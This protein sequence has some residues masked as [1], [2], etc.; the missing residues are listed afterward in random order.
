VPFRIHRPL[1]TTAGVVDDV[2]ETVADHLVEL[3]RLLGKRVF[4]LR[5]PELIETERGPAVDD[6]VADAVRE[7]LTRPLTPKRTTKTRRWAEDSL[8]DVFNR[9]QEGDTERSLAE[10]IDLTPELSELKYELAESIDEDA[11]GLDF[12]AR[13]ILSPAYPALTDYLLAIAFHVMGLREVNGIRNFILKNRNGVRSLADYAAVSAA[14]SIIEREQLNV[15]GFN[16]DDGDIVA[17]IRRAKLTLSTATFEDD[18]RVVIDDQIFNRRELQLIEDAE[19]VI[20]DI[21]DALKP[22]LVK[23]IRSSPVAIEKSNVGFFLPLFISQ[24]TG[25]VDVGEQDDVALAQSDR[26][27]EVEFFTDDRSQIQVSRSAVKCAAQLY[28]TM[29]LGDELGVFDVVNFFT[30]KYLLREGFEIEDARLRNDLQQYVFSNKFTVVDPRTNLKQVVERTRPAERHMFYRQVFDTN[31]GEATEDLIVN[32]EFSRL[33]KVLILESAKYLQRAQSSPHPDAFVSPQPVMQAVEDLQYNLS[34]H[35]TG[36][37]TVATP[38]IYDELRFVTKRIL[39]HPEVLRHVVPHGGTWW[40]VVEK[41]YAQM[42]GTRPR[43]TVLSNKA[44]F[45]HDIIRAIAEYE[46]GPFTE[47][48]GEFISKV[49]AFIITQSILQEALTDDLKAGPP[50]SMAPPSTNGGVLGP[51]PELVGVPGT[52]GSSN[53]SS[54]NGHGADSDDEWD[55]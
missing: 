7:A 8:A 21:P 42:R 28:Y 34:V 35:C 5:E 30:H 16:D 18:L 55:F 31:T 52:N 2:D 14:R 46:P 10:L 33:W 51:M 20:G 43:A 1:T 25:G 40:K 3:D 50:D 23:Y 39:M 22:Q 38:L 54:T 9:R 24:I 17:G 11:H 36:M 44:R 37:A 32:E 15:S 47:R 12:N 53:G 27:F 49:D 45:G 26:D 13:A 41:L 4:D 6:P 29:V 19:K 48:F